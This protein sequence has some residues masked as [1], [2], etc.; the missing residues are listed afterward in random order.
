MCLMMYHTCVTE[1]QPP[2][3]RVESKP[4][5]SMTTSGPLGG[6]SLNSSSAMRT[7]DSE[8]GVSKAELTPTCTCY[9]ASVIDHI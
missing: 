1:Q 7:G 3:C 8:G 4:A 6:S 9:K 2:T 5:Q